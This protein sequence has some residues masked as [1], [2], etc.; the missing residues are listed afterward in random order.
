MWSVAQCY[1][2]NYQVHF[3]NDF[4]PA[5]PKKNGGNLILFGGFVTHL[6]ASWTV[7][8][9]WFLNCYSNSGRL[10]YYNN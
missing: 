2:S 5:A 1:T 9:G 3:Y 4:S 6:I 10:Y 7:V 8:A